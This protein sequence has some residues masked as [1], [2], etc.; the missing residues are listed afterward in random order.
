MR[1]SHC[2]VVSQQQEKYRHAYDPFFESKMATFLPQANVE[3]RITAQSRRPFSNIIV[4]L[5]LSLYI[6]L[7]FIYTIAVSV[8]YES[9]PVDEVFCIILLPTVI[10]YVF[11]FPA[12]FLKSGLFLLFYGV[13][14][15]LGIYIWKYGGVTQPYAGLLD[16]IL[17]VKYFIIYWALYFLIIRSSNLRI[18]STYVARSLIFFA[19]VNAP[20]TIHDSVV[21]VNVYGQS[22]LYRLGM[23]QA[24]G[25]LRHQ[26]DAS[27]VAMLG[28][29]AAFYLLVC[30]FSFNRLLCVVVCWVSLILTF[31]IKENISVIISLVFLLSFV[32]ITDRAKRLPLS[33]AMLRLVPIFAIAGALL[34]ISPVGTA[35]F[36]QIG[37][38]AGSNSE[39]QARTVLTKTSVQIANDH[40]PIGSGAGTFA[41]ST[42]YKMGYSE[43]YSKY[44]LKYIWGASEENPT[45]LTDVFWPKILGQSGYVGLVFFI[46]AL[47]VTLWPSI[48]S[49][50]ASA[51]ADS[52]FCFSAV[53]C[54]LILSSSAAPYSAEVS[55]VPLALLAAMGSVMAHN[56]SR[57]LKS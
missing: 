49:F 55:M 22:L 18:S 15:I 11:N 19:I 28:T 1:L 44:N 45:F 52:W 14:D 24:Q 9:T 30:K 47:G 43:V 51:S 36:E 41:S 54:G 3:M 10:L 31:S 53:L 8:K 34:I 16:A 48:S 29:L 20:F 27:V 5:L 39:D 40:F 25:L 42:S 56:R 32:G 17:D 21:G 23:P 2:P 4:A 38:Y 35:L 12:H 57:E 13:A 26:F 46:I 6:A 37:K 7:R 50:F 33:M